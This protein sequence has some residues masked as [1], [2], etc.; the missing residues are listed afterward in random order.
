MIL[1]DSSALVCAVQQEDG[2][3]RLKELI[4]LSRLVAV[5]APMVLEAGIVLSQ[6]TREGRHALDG[7]LRECQAEFLEFRR[8]HSDVALS[9]FLR[10]GKG[11]HPAGLN[12]GDCVCYS[13]ARLS[14][15]TLVYKGGDFGQTDLAKL[16]RLD[17]ESE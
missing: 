12:F 1:L 10:F 4:G 16:E 5:G 15:L 17:G 3:E 8:E 6:R 2:V 11:R 13:Y 7:F 14:G 9:A